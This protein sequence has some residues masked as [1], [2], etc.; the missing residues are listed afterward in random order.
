MA[1]SKTPRKNKHSGCSSQTEA[2]S[3][4]K[5][6]MVNIHD[7]LD[8]EGRLKALA[9]F[10]SCLCRCV[11]RNLLHASQVRK[12]T[13]NN[14]IYTPEMY[15]YVCKKGFSVLVRMPGLARLCHA[16]SFSIL[17]EIVGALASA[18]VKKSLHAH[19]IRTR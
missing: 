15:K 1:T 14:T 8:T 7:V 10:C 2:S 19:W 12:A 11:F 3:R 13:T 17:F 9:I 16:H 18:T 6:K 5:S 4:H